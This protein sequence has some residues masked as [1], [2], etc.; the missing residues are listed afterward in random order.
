MDLNQNMQSPVLTIPAKPLSKSAAA[1]ATTTGARSRKVTSLAFNSA[2]PSLL[3]CCDEQGNVDVLQLSSRLSA[4]QNGEAAIL[5]R[6]GRA[7]D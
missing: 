7:V 1:A 6:M 3:A 4:L 2:D 5:E